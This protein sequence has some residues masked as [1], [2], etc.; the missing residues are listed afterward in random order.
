MEE[1][2]PRIVS[3]AIITKRI[4]ADFAKSTSSATAKFRE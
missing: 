3:V 4:M 1:G 2:L